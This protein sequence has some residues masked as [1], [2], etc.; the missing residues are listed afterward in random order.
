MSFDKV[1]LELEKI[2]V[3]TLADQTQAVTPLTKLQRTILEALK[4]PLDTLSM[5]PA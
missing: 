4:V 5:Q 3:V 1:L 2:R